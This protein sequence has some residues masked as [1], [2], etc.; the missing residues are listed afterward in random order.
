MPSTP[1]VLGNVTLGFEP[2]W[3]RLRRISGYRLWVDAPQHSAV[4]ATHLLQALGD[5]YPFSGQRPL[6]LHV[7]N[8]PLLLSLLDHAAVPGIGLIIHPELLADALLAGR[9]RA[10]HGRGTALVWHGQPGARMPAQHASWFS[11]ELRALSPQESLQALR[12]ALRQHHDPGFAPDGGAG[13]PLQRGVVYEGLATPSLV[14][15]ALD[16]QGAAAVVG[17]PAEEV[18]HQYRY[19]QILPAQDAILALMRALDDDASLERIEQLLGQEPLLTY[20]FLRWMN[21]AAMGLQRGIDSVRPGLM[22]VGLSRLREWLLAQLPHANSDPN[23]VPVRFSMVLRA[24]TMEFLCEAGAEEELRRE[25]FLCG[26]FSQMDL[27]LGEPLGNAM[28]RLPLS[29]RVE[30]AI[31]GQTG[32]YAPWLEVATALESSHTGMIREVCRAHDVALE[33]AN[34]ALLRALAGAAH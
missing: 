15:H 22:A 33:A 27:L 14:E 34:R 8:E 1:S 32:P 3:N 30:S 24:R 13:S 25:V 5:N 10:A 16:Q 12:C 31:L 11:Q 29:G 26:L 7:R 19:R 28:A 21:S 20:R 9:V 2:Q 18:L 4:D 23:L 17:W 6:W